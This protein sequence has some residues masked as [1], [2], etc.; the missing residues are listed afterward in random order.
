MFVVVFCAKQARNC[1]IVY[2]MNLHSRQLVMSIK[3]LQQNIILTSPDFIKIN[4]VGFQA[5]PSFVFLQQLG[6]VLAGNKGT[7]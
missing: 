6:K 3:L 7:K 1:P 5:S 4:F 2:I